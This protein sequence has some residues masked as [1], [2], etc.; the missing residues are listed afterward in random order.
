MNPPI[1]KVTVE[2]MRIQVMHAMSDYTGKINEAIDT[3]LK[4]AVDNFDFEAIIQEEVN[5]QVSSM[6]QDVVRDTMQGIR[7]DMRFKERVRNMVLES[8]NPESPET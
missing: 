3:E 8:L 5:N 2:S 6:C 1:V 7:Y 4:K